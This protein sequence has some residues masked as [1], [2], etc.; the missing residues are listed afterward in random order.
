[1]YADHVFRVRLPAA[2]RELA[3]PGSE[4]VAQRVIVGVGL[5]RRVVILN[6]AGLPVQYIKGD[7]TSPSG[8]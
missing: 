3:K 8:G 6:R 1:L 7:G 4:A 5:Q 2:S